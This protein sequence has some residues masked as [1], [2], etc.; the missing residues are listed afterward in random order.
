MG[1]TGFILDLDRTL[2]V[3]PLDIE[4]VRAGLRVWA[5]PLGIDLPFRPILDDLAA[6]PMLL[7]PAHGDRAAALAEEAWARF[8]AAEAD[9]AVHAHLLPGAAELLD[10]LRATGAP[11]ALVTNNGRPGVLAALGAVGVDAGEFDAIICRREARAPKPDPDGFRLAWGALQA[12][13]PA[14]KA[15]WC[16][17]DAPTDVAAA[18]GLAAHLAEVSPA[19]RV[20]TLGV[21]TG[22][23]SEESLRAAGIDAVVPSLTLEK[24]QEVWDKHRG[25]V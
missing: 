15:L 19:V 25:V 24:L 13:E 18:R 7:R 17:G 6:L 11:R 23:S 21:T 20:F 22:P 9:A 14:L 10:H 16:M 4:A 3:L 8:D 5:A 12:R 1:H 2:L